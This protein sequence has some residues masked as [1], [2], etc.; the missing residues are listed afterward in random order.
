MRNDKQREK[1]QSLT[2]MALSITVIFILLG[3]LIDCMQLFFDFMALRD[4]A[5]EGVNYGIYNPADTSGIVNRVTGA[6][7]SPII[8]EASQVLPT[9]SGNV[10]AS[11]GIACQGAVITVTV[12]YQY[13]I[14]APFLGTLIGGQ[15][16]PISTNAKGTVVSPGC[17]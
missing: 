7:N 13:T 15:T 14:T 17:S 2:E 10:N 4:A 5:K 12:Q 16:F 9:F 11:S 3:G 1:G 8:I 6:S